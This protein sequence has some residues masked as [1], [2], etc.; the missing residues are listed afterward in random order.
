MG[1]APSAP[2]GWAVGPEAG[3]HVSGPPE[4]GH[5]VHR[6]SGRRDGLSPLEPLPIVSHS[7]VFKKWRARQDSNLRPP[8]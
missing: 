2:G 6:D 4:G 1:K 5:Y 8:A 3:S 7:S